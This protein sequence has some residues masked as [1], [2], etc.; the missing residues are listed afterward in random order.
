MD[1]QDPYKKHMNLSTGGGGERTTGDFWLSGKLQA[2]GNPDL[3]RV[4]QKVTEWAGHLRSS[5]GLCTYGYGQSNT[6]ACINIHTHACT[7]IYA[8]ACTHTYKKQTKAHLFLEHAHIAKKWTLGSP[9]NSFSQ[10]P[11]G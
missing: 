8:H 11:I 6:H 1:P 9:K 4:R 7:H 5:P 10:T 3:K 2:H